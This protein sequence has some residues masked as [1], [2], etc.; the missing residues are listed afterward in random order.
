[1]VHGTHNAL[2]E[3]LDRLYQ[4]AATIGMDTGMSRAEL[5]AALEQ[6]Q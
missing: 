1:M 2:D 4:G 5:A 6:T 3:H